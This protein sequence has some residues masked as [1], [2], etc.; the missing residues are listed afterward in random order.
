[1]R[2]E[3]KIIDIRLAKETKALLKRKN[4]VIYALSN[5]Y[6]SNYYIDLNTLEFEVVTGIDYVDEMIGT[7]GNINDAFAIMR[8]RLIVRADREK[9]ARFM[10]F[11]TL[12]ERIGTKQN[13]SEEFRSI[14]KGW[15]RGSFI[16][17]D[18]DE[19]GTVKQVMYVVENIN[20]SKKKELDIQ[21]KLQNALYEANLANQAKSEFLTRMSHDIRTPING[22]LGMLEISEKNPDDIDK[23]MECHDKIRI[24]ANY[25]LA[26][27]SDVLDMSKLEM[28]RMELTNEPFDA[29]ELIGDCIEILRPLAAENSISLE[30]NSLENIRYR[31]L[32]GSPL[33]IRQIF[34][35][36]A[37]NAIKFNRP[38]GK[39][40][41]SF[42][43]EAYDSKASIVKYRITMKDTGIGMSDEFQKSMFD[44]FTQENSSARTQ[45]E[46]TG[47]GLAIVKRLV[48]LLDGSIQVKS[49]QGRGSTFTVILPFKIDN[50]ADRLAVQKEEVHSL[51]GLNVLIVEDN[52]LNM[53]IACFLLEDMDITYKAVENGQLAV[54]E[55]RNSPAG[56]YDVILMDIMMP[57]M[58]GYTATKAIRSL[59]NGDAGT[60]P[61]I[62]MTANAYADDVAKSKEAGMTAHLA[63]PIDTKKLYNLLHEYHDKKLGN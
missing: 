36:L 43:E 31:Y 20:I 60:I 22:I 10:D 25:L 50:S 21:E 12:K 37:T 2:K 42:R 19:W 8:K 4:E 51:S 26:L 33:H 24:S 55:F 63:K 58:D 47:L 3:D 49:K 16:V 14:R 30:V 32:I 15:C 7:N 38:G 41:I 44:S 29:S 54:E 28:G 13:I 45:Y 52:K 11:N 39:V 40:I 56:E 23:L 46:G 17:A 6:I 1:M 34:I 59:D 61:I 57:V 62:A 53:E 48:E 9:M 18:R 35:N 5:I 27:I